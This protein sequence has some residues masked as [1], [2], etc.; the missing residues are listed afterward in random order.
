MGSCHDSFEEEVK[1]RFN[2]D[3]I[4]FGIY[5]RKY[6]EKSFMNKVF[7]CINDIENWKN[8]ILDFIQF[9]FNLN[10]EK[11]KNILINI[12]KI[13]K[14]E[15]DDIK[16]IPK[17]CLKKSNS[18]KEEFQKDDNNIKNNDVF[19]SKDIQNK[20]SEIMDN[21]KRF[22][23]RFFNDTEEIEN[24]TFGEY[25]IKIANLSRISYNDSNI[26]LKIMYYDYESLKYKDNDT[27]ISSLE[28]FREEFSSWAKNNNEMINS[29]LK[30]Y[31][32]CEKIPYI[33]EE[34]DKNSKDYFKKL[35]EELVLLYFQCELSFPSIQID[36]SNNE[37]D[38]N[39]D[40]M[41]EYPHNTGNKKIVN[42]VY[43]PSLSS[44]DNYIEKGKKWVFTYI[45]NNKKKTFYY[46]DIK[47][48]PLFNEKQKFSVPKLS[49]KLK[50]NMKKYYIPEINYSLSERVRKEYIFHL[51]DK[52]RRIQIKSENPIKI[53]ENIKF[54]SC[55]FYL[56][57]NYI[58]SY[59]ENIEL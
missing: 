36:F 5:L 46:E 41:I 13:L 37:S 44:N 12:K 33:D 54:L 10:N 38:F 18:I 34:K 39:Y 19:S 57:N 14:I 55:D 48:E 28:Q 24:Q 9:N 58:T 21:F 23:S 17:K 16:E 56:M 4:D 30:E 27:I 35:Y 51:L 47:L 8:E 25:L 26:F 3:I 49:D 32:K 1:K 6:I 50:L 59:S 52:K 15:E 31:L 29:K 2:E 7:L 11:I 22:S 53:N 43:F 20:L 45:N 40:K 42:F